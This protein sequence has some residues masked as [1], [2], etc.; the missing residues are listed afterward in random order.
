MG[1][2][3][4]VQSDGRNSMFK[5]VPR[6]HFCFALSCTSFSFSRLEVLW[7]SGPG[8]FYPMNG[9]RAAHEVTQQYYIGNDEATKR[10]GGVGNSTR[11]LG[12]VAGGGAKKC[13]R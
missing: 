7:C 6:C 8:S 2:C 13:G 12:R 10:K 3:P 9:D 4:R 11:F 5:G 1:W